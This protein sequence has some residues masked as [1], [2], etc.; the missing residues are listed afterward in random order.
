MCTCVF[1]R[2]RA[3]HMPIRAHT[4]TDTPVMVYPWQSF[5][6]PVRLLANLKRPSSVSTNRLC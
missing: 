3:P 5:V 1:V 2:V 4:E 6:V